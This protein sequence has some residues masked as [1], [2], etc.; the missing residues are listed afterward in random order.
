M[1]LCILSKNGGARCYADVRSVLGDVGIH[2]KVKSRKNMGE[3]KMAKKK[4][5]AKHANKSAAVKAS[6]GKSPKGPVKKKVVKR[7]RLGE[8]GKGRPLVE[9]PAK[10]VA[11]AETAPAFSTKRPPGFPIVGIGASAGGLEA[12]EAFFKNMPSDAGIGFVLVVHLDPKHVSILPEILQ[13]H[14]QMPVRQIKDGMRVEPNHVYVIPPNRDLTILNGS[15]QLLELTQPR[16][17]NL[18]IDSFLR[19]LAQDQGQN[20][21]CVILSGTGSDGTMGVKAVKGEMGMVMVQD[22]GSAKYDGMPR[23]AIATGLADFVL[24]PAKMPE[25][26]VQ[27]VTHATQTDVGKIVDEA[28]PLSNSLQKIFAIL[29][30]QTGHDFSLYKK[31]TICRRIERRMNINQIDDISDY[32][33]Y[34]QKSNHEANILFKELLIGV[35]SFFRE[36]DAFE[37]LRDVL[38]KLLPGKPEN[39]TV[40]VWV[41]GCATG[42]EAYSV[43]ILL[44]ECM[45]ELQR[46]FHVQIFGTDID[47]DAI[48]VA[49]AGLY[50]ESIMADVNAE[51]MHRHFTKEGE[52]Q[53]RVKKAIRE[54]LV[55]ALQNVIKDPPFTKLDLICC[56]NLLIYL[57][58]E[59][60]RKLL[61]IFHYSLK[62]DGIL[63]LGSSET[64]GPLTDLFSTSHK[65]WKIYRRKPVD[66]TARPQLAFTA[67]ASFEESRE[68]DIPDTVQKVEELSALQLVETILQQTET[69]PCA[70]INDRCDVV[71]IHG[72]T[73][74]FLEPAEGKASVNIIEMARPGLKTDL[75]VAIREVATHK[76]EV[77]RRN[78][79]VQP[80]GDTITLNMTVKPILKQTALRGLMMV[81]FE[82]A[83]AVSRTKGA[84]AKPPAA[85]HGGKSIQKLEEEL[86]YTRESLQTTIEELETANEELKSTNEELQSTNEELQSTNEELET[87]KEELQSLNEE[88]ATV[89]AEL[90]ARIDELNER[91]DDMK[92]LLDATQIATIFLDADLRVRRFTPKSTDL[93][94][95]TPTDIGRPIDHLSSKIIDIDLTSYGR[96]VLGDLA[97]Q[98]KEV[99]SR[100]G[101]SYIMRVRP[102][103]TTANV[104]DGVVL[105]FEDITRI[106]RA[107]EAE[108]LAVVVHDSYDAITLQNQNGAIVAWNR[109]AERM[110]GYTEAEALQMNFMDLV[111]ESDRNSALDLVR[112]A[113]RG[114][115]IR[116]CETTRLAK[117][118]RTLA[119]QLTATLIP[120]KEG[121]P[122]FIATTERNI[123]EH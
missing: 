37:V 35:T 112:R 52:G 108:R 10:A 28:G 77:V 97:V 80:N 53:Y 30:S 87:S 2:D 48:D 57:G 101:H 16:G 17:V 27:Y 82:E 92:N 76:Q 11:T 91:T 99:V 102:Y 4:Q 6:V 72:R 47:E 61:P 62:P 25:Q 70:I 44:H 8:A 66:A 41:P 21:I 81:V 50:P 96:Q 3:Y 49:R 94:P 20:A 68:M 115:S 83:A 122:E 116:Y 75:A 38:M 90:Q 86:H 42:E 31:N 1:T 74:R 98:E 85:K 54:M 65:K 19:S 23:S 18:P 106:K 39:Y 32:V 79:R 60:Q 95:L 45:E 34:L 105:T 109:G 121:K 40:R 51:R 117:D 110:Y 29:R 55:F 93:V 73:G 33:R 78:L 67:A 123:T 12:L 89:N 84:K 36:R 64:I 26:L 69:P 100:E 88:S 7:G 22:E 103:R 15:L 24:S 59:L 14:T 107:E 63:F 114:E 71:Y 113:F 120:G 13:K 43:A 56:R 5:V 119:V 104:I 9:K 111:P 58:P 118:G 46:S